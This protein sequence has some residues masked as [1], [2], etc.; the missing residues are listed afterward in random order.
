MKWGF[1]LLVIMPIIATQ[2]IAQTP[3]GDIDSNGC[4]NSCGYVW[5]D[6]PDIQECIRI[7]EVECD[8][9]EVDTPH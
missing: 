9:I 3:G 1:W 5:C 7:W 6:D 2:I 8:L 4:C